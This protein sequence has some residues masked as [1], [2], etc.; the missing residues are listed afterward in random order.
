LSASAELLVLI[1]HYIRKTKTKT[2]S[3]ADWAQ[4]YCWIQCF[5]MRS[6]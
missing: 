1:S 6:F 2:M 3:I 4:D 5:T